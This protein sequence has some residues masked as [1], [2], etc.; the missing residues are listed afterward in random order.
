[1]KL[2]RL[3]ITKG[4][5][6][7]NGGGIQIIGAT[8]NLINCKVIHNKTKEGEGGGIFVNNA[9]VSLKSC[10]VNHN[11]ASFTGSGGGILYSQPLY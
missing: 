11:Q 7:G 5:N 4:L 6:S 3:E 10:Y 2:D 9:N 1:M 8:V